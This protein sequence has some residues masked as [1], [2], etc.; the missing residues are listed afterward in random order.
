[1]PLAILTA[2]VLPS[3]SRHSLLVSSIGAADGSR[4]G[5]VQDNA[6]HICESQSQSNYWPTDRIQCHLFAEWFQ[7]AALADY[8]VLWMPLGPV[9]RAQFDAAA[10]W[11]ERGKLLGLLYGFPNLLFGRRLALAASPPPL[12]PSLFSRRLARSS[13]SLP[14][15]LVSEAVYSL[16]QAGST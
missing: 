1:M 15:C 2:A 3:L 13:P 12:P 11:E 4:R 16:R 9:A 8:N 10:A 6:L 5:E 14:S 7:L